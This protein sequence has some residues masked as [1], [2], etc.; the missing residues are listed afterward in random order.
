[1]QQYHSLTLFSETAEIFGCILKQK[2]RDEGKKAGGG[3]ELEGN[4]W[5]GKAL[6]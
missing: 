6:A 1:M 4:A 3:K 2:D 5:H